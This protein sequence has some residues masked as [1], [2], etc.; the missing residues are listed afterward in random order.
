M[1]PYNHTD[2]QTHNHTDMQPYIHT[3]MH[4]RN[5]EQTCTLEM[6]NR[7]ALATTH[8]HYNQAQ[9]NPTKGRRPPN[10]DPTKGRDDGCR[11]H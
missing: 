11:Q 8:R 9:E 5:V 10:R 7:R 6:T 3:D 1:Q 2:M 4:T